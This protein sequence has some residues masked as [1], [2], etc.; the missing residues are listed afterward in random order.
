MGVWPQVLLELDRDAVEGIDDIARSN[1]VS[2][3][4]NVELHWP[5]PTKALINLHAMA[6]ST[7][8][9]RWC[10]EYTVL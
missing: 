6:C 3:R 1:C 8:K 2:A 5:A 4:P 7:V 10:K 9:N